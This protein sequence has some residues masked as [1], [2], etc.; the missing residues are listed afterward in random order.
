MLVAWAIAIPF[1]THGFVG[2]KFEKG[3]AE[4][5]L[6]RISH[7][8]VGWGCHHLKT[9]HPRQLILVA[10]VDVGYWLRAQLELLTRELTCGLFR[11]V[12]SE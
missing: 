2:Q 12:V 11:M 9:G 8:D 6:L 7:A 3:S 4:K 5:F 1:L 10:R